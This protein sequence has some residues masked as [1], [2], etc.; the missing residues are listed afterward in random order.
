MR[1]RNP[2]VAVGLAILVSTV[3][4]AVRPARAADN[5]PEMEDPEGRP[6]GGYVALPE[7][8]GSLRFGPGPQRRIVYMNRNGGTVYRGQNNSSTNTSSIPDGTS[9]L[10]GWE[11]SN[12]QW[13]QLMTCSRLMFARFDVEVTDVDPGNVAHIE[14][15]VGG[16]PQEIGMSNGVGGVAPVNTN[17]SVVERA[18]VFTFAG[19]YGNNVQSICETVA[20]E[21]SHALG[22]DHEVLCEDPMTYLNGCGA[23]TF[24]D[25]DA[26][27]GEGT[28]R[29]CMC[30]GNKQNSVQILLDVLGPADTAPP[31]VQL[32]S[33]AAGAQ[34]APGFAITAS[35]S[36]DQAVTK[37]DLW[38]DGAFVAS[39]ASASYTFS[40]PASLVAGAHSLEVRA[41]DG[42]GNISTDVAN[43]T[44]VVPCSGNA[45]CEAGDLCQ[46][47]QCVPDPNG[48]GG[49]GGGPDAGGGGGGGGG[50]GGGGG[51]GGD[52]SGTVTGGCDVGVHGAGGT[53]L[54]ALVLG[55][56]ALVA[57]ALSRRSARAS[58]RRP[59]SRPR[60]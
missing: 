23:K 17:C 55:A 57:L 46:A 32:T 7:E 48:G 9:Q 34:V 58:V 60:I 28:P 14:S 41:Y 36:D 22:L 2:R 27:C 15:M 5:A 39:D 45:D 50:D 13:S 12:T 51:G 54:G 43:V 24:Q 20:Q 19:V 59:R 29:A 52:D 37:V 6:R 38:I 40:A 1:M 25:F 26:N 30:G 49:G 35:A 33:P 47:G 42:A 53:D 44:L 31:M 56:A 3:A 21:T 8:P 10:T 18:I 11:L 16:Y 4:L